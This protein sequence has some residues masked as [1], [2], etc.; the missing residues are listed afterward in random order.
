M[1]STVALLACSPMSGPPVSP[2]GS[3][4][5]T[6]PQAT[7]P[8]PTPSPMRQISYVAIG[9]SDT[10]GVGA[11]NPRTGSW[12][13]RLAARL[14]ADATYLNLGVSGSLANQARTAQVPRAI[15]ARPT[16]VT[17]WLAVN[18][19]TTGLQP[20][21]YEIDLTSVIDP[22]LNETQARI[23]IGNVPDL[24]GV[25]AFSSI[26]PAALNAFIGSYNDAINA[27]AARNPDRVTVVDLFTGSAELVSSSTVADDGFHPSDAGY[28]LIAERFARALAAAGVPLRP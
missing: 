15:A 18:D 14:P 23:F 11:A 2:S 20:A 22:L 6:S 17:V 16:L 19:L 7:V 24:R 3:A 27:V 4:A 26:D 10:V 13:A 5:P 25:P 12:P 28:V 21:Q 9:A 1:I 8:S